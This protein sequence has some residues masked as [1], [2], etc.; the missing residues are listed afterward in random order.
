MQLPPP[1]PTRRRDALSVHRISTM[2]VILAI[3]V[4]ALAALGAIW[5]WARELPRWLNETGL[6]VMW[7]SAPL[8]GIVSLILAS[9]VR[10]HVRKNPATRSVNVLSSTATAM[11]FAWMAVAFWTLELLTGMHGI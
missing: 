11:V 4:L 5:G 2:A 10:R 6:W 1:P 8:I 9:Y 7:V 3:M